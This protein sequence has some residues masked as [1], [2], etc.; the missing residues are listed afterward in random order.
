MLVIRSGANEENLDQ[1]SN[2]DTTIDNYAQGQLAQLGLTFF[3]EKINPPTSRCK[4][5]HT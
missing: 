4:H 5:K 1:K 3:L 2:E